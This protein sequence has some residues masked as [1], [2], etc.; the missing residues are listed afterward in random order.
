MATALRDQ[1]VD[2]SLKSFWLRGMRGPH[3]AP[4]NQRDARAAQLVRGVN[5]CSDV[6]GVNECSDSRGVKKAK[7]C[8]GGIKCHDVWGVKECDGA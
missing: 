6:R 1:R 7:E 2:L 5:E 3:A 4:H 8:T